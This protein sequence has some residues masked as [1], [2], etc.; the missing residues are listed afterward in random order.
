VTD[1]ERERISDA[2][3]FPVTELPGRITAAG[4]VVLANDTGAYVHPDLSETAV[5]AVETAIGCLRTIEESN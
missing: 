2:V 4:N 1:R 5:D 3:D